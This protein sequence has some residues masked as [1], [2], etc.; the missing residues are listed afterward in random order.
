[1]AGCE[2]NVPTKFIYLNYGDIIIACGVREVKLI[3]FI[4]LVLASRSD[5]REIQAPKSNHQIT[6][7]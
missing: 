1:M 4:D 2:G 6:A 3:N 7:M 5:Y